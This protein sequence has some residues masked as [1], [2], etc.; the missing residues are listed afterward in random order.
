MWQQVKQQRGPWALFFQKPNNHFIMQSTEKYF[1][2]TAS[3]FDW[4][5]SEEKTIRA[6]GFNHSIPGPFLRAKKGDEITIKVKNNLKEP[7]VVHWHGIRLPS[8]MDGTTDTQ[9]PIQPG[10]E[11]EYRFIVPDAGTFW[12]HSHHNETV[13][14]E[15]GMYGALIVED[16][17][18]LAVDKERILMIDDMKLTENNEFRKGNAFSR[19]FQRHDGREGETLLINGKENSV[20]EMNAGQIERWRIINASSAKYFYLSLGGKP[21][22]IIGT[23][24]GLLEQPI[25]ATE[26][27]IIPGE[28]LEILVGPF[29]EDEHYFIESL[30]YNRMTSIKPKHQQYAAV[31]VKEAKPSVA[32]IPSKLRT[33]ETLAAQQATVTRSVK[34]SVGPSWRHG[35]DFLVNNDV[36]TADAPV[37]INELQVW[38]VSNTSLMDHPFH[39]HGFFFQVIEENG[40]APSYNAWKDTYNLKPR[41]KVKIAW[42]PDRTGNWM[43]HCHILEHHEA[44][45]MAHFE[46]IDPAIGSAHSRHLHRSHHSHHSHAV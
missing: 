13:Q 38:E 33:I 41:S 18:E 46:V 9:K 24:G 10:E 35:I 5:V 42:V 37:N 22:K 25:E 39:L 12:Y 27:L 44:G 19:W 36:H 8:E 4:K 26:S 17:T 45:M 3:E 14:M 11:F 7:T 28:R 23:D 21:F 1:E 15:R 43:Y 6:W 20:F 29:S 34:F 30:P 31:K 16:E 2:L 32:S 40:Q